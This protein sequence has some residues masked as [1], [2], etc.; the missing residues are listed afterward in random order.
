M[1]LITVFVAVCPSDPVV[2]VPVCR[3]EIARTY[4][5]EARVKHLVKKVSLFKQL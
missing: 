1:P 3:F 5:N 2:V 4:M